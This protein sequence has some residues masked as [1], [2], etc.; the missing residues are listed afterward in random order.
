MSGLFFDV[1]NVK[2]EELHCQSY[3]LSTTVTSNMTGKLS[4]TIRVWMDDNIADKT[5]DICQRLVRPATWEYNASVAQELYRYNENVDITMITMRYM[6]CS[7]D[8]NSEIYTPQRDVKYK[9]KKLDMY[10]DLTRDNLLKG[11]L[12]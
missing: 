2:Q 4:N 1:L 12:F 11:M 3:I 7:V 10:K 9:L 8:V 5:V 6:L